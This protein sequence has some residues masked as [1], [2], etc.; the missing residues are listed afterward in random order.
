MSLVLDDITN[1]IKVSETK[2]VTRASEILGMTQPALSYSIKRLEREL[3]GDLL[4]R[5]KNGI[6]LTKLGEEFL[7]R[8]RQLV[9]NWQEAQN[10]VHPDEEGFVGKYTF[11]IHPSV[12]LYS[13]DKFI[14]A[15]A[16]KFP[17][18]HIDFIHGWSREM[19]EKVISWEADFGIVVNPIKHPD[20]VIK[21]LCTDVVTIFAKASPQ[22]KLILDPSLVQSQYLLK[23]LKKS[24]LYFEEQMTTSNLEVASKLTSLGQGYGLLPTRVASHYPA[25]KPIKDAPKFND[26]ICLVYRPEKHRNTLSK[27]IIKIVSQAKI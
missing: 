23:K 24:N 9:F 26:E 19:T 18:V 7:L 2:N 10:L 20:L 8:S 3:G 5:L 25:L 1:F 13:L 6:E 16:K 15:L 14:P 11:A 21:R 4:I 12:A 17:K 27:E 22:K